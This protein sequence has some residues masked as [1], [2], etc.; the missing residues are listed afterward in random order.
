MTI[1]TL[2]AGQVTDDDVVDSAYAVLGELTEGTLSGAAVQRRRRRCA[3]GRSASSAMAQ[4]TR[5]GHCT[6]TSRASSSALV[7]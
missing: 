5:S 6:P 4:T 1:R 7:V 2:E 3:V